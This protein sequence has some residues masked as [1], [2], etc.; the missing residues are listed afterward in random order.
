[1]SEKIFSEIKDKMDQAV[2]VLQKEFATIRSGRASMSMLD[3]IKVESYG[4]LMPVNQLATVTIPEAKLIVIQPWD[5]SVLKNIEKAIL[6]SD[7]GITPS[8]DGNIIRIPIPALNEERRKELVK[9]VHKKAEDCKVEVRNIRR[10]GNEQIKGEEKSKKI[11]EDDSKRF[12]EK[13]QELTD[14]HIETIDA[15]T[16]KK[17]T[18]IM[19]I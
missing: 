18:E 5:K 3:G 6:K 15:I 2:S 7:M 16:K 1:M 12:L 4:T 10:T 14:K 19:E 11:S 13:V 17:E 8:S 9:V